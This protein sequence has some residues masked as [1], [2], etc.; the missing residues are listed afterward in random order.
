[1]NSLIGCGV[2][3]GST[4]LFF[5]TPSS[6]L[7]TSVGFRLPRSMSSLSTQPSELLPWALPADFVVGSCPGKILTGLP[8]I[9]VLSGMILT[10]IVR[11]IELHSID[12]E[13]TIALS[14]EHKFQAGLF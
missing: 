1:M 11:R 14:V 6:F 8:G 13:S 9:M 12:P 2:L 5:L 7:V 10:S 3:V 4:R